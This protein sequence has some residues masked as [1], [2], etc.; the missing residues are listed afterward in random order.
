MTICMDCME[1]TMETVSQFDY[2]SMMNHPAFI[3]TFGQ[4]TNPYPQE[5]KDEKSEKKINDDGQE[6]LGAEETEDDVEEILRF[7]FS[8]LPEAL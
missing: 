3:N 7:L 4:F 8:S 5:K 1:K 6:I 2:G